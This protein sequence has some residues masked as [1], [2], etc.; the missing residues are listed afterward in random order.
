[1][2]LSLWMPLRGRGEG[3]RGVIFGGVSGLWF[4]SEVS[5]NNKVR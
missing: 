1:M 2:R 4:R 5:E 3:G